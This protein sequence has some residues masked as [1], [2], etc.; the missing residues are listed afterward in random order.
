MRNA[1]YEKGRFVW[2]CDGC[3][4]QETWRKGWMRWDGVV[5][6]D[7]TA[8]VACS[9]ACED[10]VLLK[11]CGGVEV[12]ETELVDGEPYCDVC[13]DSGD[14]LQSDRVCSRRP[15]LISGGRP[16]AGQGGAG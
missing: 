3:G 11:A 9:D 15:H 12:T 1:G 5:H 6:Q 8:M 4:K 10:I 14:Q 7:G 16:R 2:T 13:G